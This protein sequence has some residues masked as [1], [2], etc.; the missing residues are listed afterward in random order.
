MGIVLREAPRAGDASQLSALL[1]SVDRPELGQAD[2]Q[3]AV[4]VM[5]AVEDTDVVGT[6]H[7]LQHEALHLPA[8]QGVHQVPATASFVAELAQ[9]LALRKG[10]VLAVFVVGKVSAGAVEIE[11][12]DVRR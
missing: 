5:I 1:P 2:R 11:L 7:R 8:P 3:V 9:G 12:A 6:V 4:A 10:W